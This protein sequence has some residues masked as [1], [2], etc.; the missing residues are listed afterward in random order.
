MAA[1]SAACQQRIALNDG[2]TMPSFGLGVWQAP[3][4]ACKAAVLHALRCGYRHIDTAEVYGNEQDVG[5]ALAI[6]LKE[7]PDVQREDIWI[8]TKFFPRHGAGRA[9][10]VRAC[11][12]SLRKLRL[13]Y[14]DLYLIHAPHTRERLEQYRAL[15]AL[16]AEG[17]CRSIGVSNYGI[18]HLQ[19]LLA[20]CTVPPCV[21]QVRDISVWCLHAIDASVSQVE[22]NPFIT[23]SPLREFCASKGILV[24]AYSP[25]ARAK[26]FRDQRLLDVARRC[27]LTPAQVMIRWCLQRGCIV[28]PKSVTPARIEENAQLGDAPLSAADMKSLDALDEHFVTHWDPTRS[29]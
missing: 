10:V 28:I 15:E 22:C 6:F 12:D 7:R 11:R 16:R 2:R 5:D 4:G 18:H 13:Q 29:P 3:L 24:E 25:L 23:R 14:V 17:L 26:K 20:V 9:A 19:E 1:V 8:T 27:S 21:N